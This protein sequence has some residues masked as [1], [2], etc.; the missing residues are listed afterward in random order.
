[1]PK[2]D[3]KSL[4]HGKPWASLLSEYESEIRDLRKARRTYREISAHLKERHGVDFSYTAIWKFV[5]VRAKRTPYALPE[6]G[7]TLPPVAALR[8]AKAQEPAAAAVPEAA[9]A[10]AAK[11]RTFDPQTDNNGFPLTGRAEVI[12]RDSAGRPLTRNRPFK[13]QV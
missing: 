3:P 1:M 12:G 4:P 7:H 2:K 11:P 13:G 8:P 9:P 10:P 5:R 6:P